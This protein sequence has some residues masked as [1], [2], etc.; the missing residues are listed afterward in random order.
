MTC[1]WNGYGKGPVSSVHGMESLRAFS[2]IEWQSFAV[3][4]KRPYNGHRVADNQLVEKWVP[5]TL[6]KFAPLQ[7]QSDRGK[8]GTVQYEGQNIFWRL[9][10]ESKCMFSFYDKFFTK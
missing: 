10:W 9:L 7:V 8:P 3:P 5:Q 2:N 4:Q 1:V 6:W